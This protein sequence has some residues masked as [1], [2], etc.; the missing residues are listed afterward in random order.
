[1]NELKSEILTDR[2]RIR[3]SGRI[4][5]VNSADIE[6][7]ILEILG[8]APGLP[9][10]LAADDLA[11][12]S[13]AGLRVILRVRK[14]CPDLFITGVNSDV[15]EILE[16][17]GFTEM[18]RVE[19]AFRVV[20]VEGAEEIGRGANGVVYRLDRDNVVKVLHNGA[21]LEDIKL[22]RELARKALILGIPTAISYDVVRVGDNYGSVYELLNATSFS[23]ILAEDPGKMD[24]CVK[25]FVGLLKKIHGTEVPH[26]DLPDSRDWLIDWADFTAAYLPEAAGKKLSAMAREVPDVDH[27]IHGDYHT[28]NVE[29][30]GDEVLLIDMDTLAVGYPVIELGSMYNASVGYGEYDPDIIKSFMGFDSDTGRV[31]WQKVLAAYLGTEN[32]RKIRAVEDKA[33]IVGYSRMIRRAIRR[34]ELE[35]E[36]GRC[37]I[38]LWKEK[39]VRLLE[40]TDTLLFT[41][42]EQVFPADKDRLPE[43]LAFIDRIL[44]EENCPA[45]IRTQVAIAAEEIF[46]NIAGYA[47]PD[48][49]G[50]VVIRAD[51][52][53]DTNTLELTF[54]DSGLPFDPEA[55][56]D[57]DVTA[58]AEERQ[59][60]GLGIFMAKK[61]MDSFR[62][63]YRDGKNI[64][65]MEKKLPGT[66]PA[67]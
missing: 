18:M 38:E 43:V 31:F 53:E 49:R 41:C 22:E 36:E 15:Y 59:I 37:T 65:K 57:P 21:S 67:A 64:L 2:V 3:L 27:M 7:G 39:L 46:I 51:V 13:S 50:N 55:K 26:G 47:Y 54:T 19:K 1:M 20:S 66:A 30:A 4:D 33:R 16:M 48:G 62:Y 11:Y 60:G 28:K 14:N 5:S 25:E 35:T 29:L 12:I 52:N 63:E 61:M 44:E 58:G 23:K 34:G 6:K 42:N 24:W 17:T 9:V 45:K 8:H 56:T 32:K 10:E 40:K